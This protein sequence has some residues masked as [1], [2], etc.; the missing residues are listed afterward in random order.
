MKPITMFMFESCPHC[1]RARTW[2]EE[3]KNENPKYQQIDVTMM[4][5]K[6]Q[7][8]IAKAYDYYYVPTYFIEGVKVHE[9]PASKE[10]IKEVFEKA[11]S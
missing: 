11:C 2:M 1:N 4:D 5:E 8:A 6:L 7:P 10:I 9:G 3:L